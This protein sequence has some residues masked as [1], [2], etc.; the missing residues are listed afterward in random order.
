MT[1]HY[2][3]IAFTDTVREHQRTH[4]SLRSYERMAAVPAVADRLTQDEAWFITERDS[5]YMATVSE[6]GW[7]YIQHRGGPRGF[8]KVL[9]AH[10]LGFADFRGNRQYISRG[11]LDHDDRVALF[12][13]D[14]AARTRLKIM[15]RARIVEAGD[16]PELIASLRTGDYKAH[17]ERAVL[18]EVEAFDWN[19]SQ[20]IPEL[21]PR[22]EVLEAVQGM[23]ERIEEL[24]RENARLRRTHA[25]DD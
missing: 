10:T 19:C 17:V 3:Q 21:Y 15:G 25:G 7:P 12:L 5:F 18:I 2:A 6:T 9:D 24:E 23:R 22:E 13:M 4:G 1:G 14:Y 8:L 16:D 11:N 20:H